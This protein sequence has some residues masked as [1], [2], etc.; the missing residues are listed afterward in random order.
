[1]KSRFRNPPNA[2][3]QESLLLLLSNTGNIGLS[4]V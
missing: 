2:I 1:M 4:L 3:A